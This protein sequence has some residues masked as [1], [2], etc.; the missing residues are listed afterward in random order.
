M[1]LAAVSNG[2]SWTLT[3]VPLPNASEEGYLRGVSCSSASTCVAVGYYFDSSVGWLPLAESWNGSTWT[4]QTA[5]VPSGALT[6]ALYDA[7]CASATACSAVGDYENSSD[8]FVPLA[9]SW[10]GSSWSSQSVPSPSGVQEG[11][12]VGLDGVACSL[13]NAC[14]AVSGYIKSVHGEPVSLAESWSGSAWSV[15][16]ISAPSGA[17][18]SGLSGVSCTVASACTAVGTY[19]NVA[20]EAVPLAESWNG[21]S[22]SPES[23]P[24][25]SGAARSELESVSCTAAS[26]CAAV[27]SYENGTNAGRFLVERDSGSVSVPHNMTA[28]SLTGTP[29]V[30]QTLTCSDGAWENE[31]TEY[32][33]HWLRGGAAISGQ[34]AATYVVQT[35]DE[36]HSITCEVTASNQ[37]GSASAVSGN[38]LT[39]AA[40]TPETK[41]PTTGTPTTSNPT[42]GA[43]KT[44]G[45]NAGGG[46]TTKALTTAEVASFLSSLPTPKGKAASIKALL[47]SG[48]YTATFKAPGGGRLVVSW[49]DVPH[50]AHVSRAKAKPVLLATATASFAAA[51]T[52]DLKV[53]LTA[54]G[55]RLL[56]KAKRAT[57]TQR[58]V[59]AATGGATLT[60]LR[61]L[62]LHR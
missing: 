61:T 5:A 18:A 46:T 30:G 59:F 41:E 45:G 54:A 55:K 26:V 24:A 34:E 43:A 14:A 10:N 13:G 35:A 15:Q 62:T 49:Y 40:T 23:P 22:W 60:K 47:K 44:S 21:S 38:A 11:T 29:A 52:N 31:P 48:G 36:G 25:P 8:E 17:L 57:L 58:A 32:A 51:G 9:E 28:P 12:G 16:S 37:A 1:P 3:S 2:S 7:S 53:K 50:G 39:A 56:R 19:N 33:Y 42:A 20:G 6:S 27:G 4:A